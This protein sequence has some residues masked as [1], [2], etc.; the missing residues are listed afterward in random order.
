MLKDQFLLWVALIA[1]V[2]V[3]GLM[4]APSESGHNTVEKRDAK[5]VVGVQQLEFSVLRGDSFESASSENVPRLV[6]RDDTLEAELINQQ[7][8]YLSRLKV[9]SHQ[10]DI[11]ILVDTGSSDLWVMDSV[12]P[13][14]S[15]RSRVKRD[16]HDEKI[17][18]WNPINLKKNETSQNK[19]FWDWLVGTSTSSP[20][21]ATATGSGS[22]SAATAVSVSS[23]QATLDCSTYG[24]F[25]HADSSTFHD[26]NTDF[27]ISYADTTFASGIWGYDDVI[28]DGIEVKELSFA[29]ADMTNSSI[30]VLGIGLKGLESTYAS[31]SSVSEMYQYDNLPAKMV[32]DGLINK[33]AYSL[34]LNSKDA[35]SGSILF[36]G[37]DHKKYSGQLLTVPVINTLASSG[38]REAIRLQIT[39][40]G[41]DVKKGSDQ[42]TLLQGR[43]A[44]LLDSGATL[45]YAP[46]SVL[47]S[48]GRNLGGSYDSSRQA[49]TIRCVSAS[50]TTSLVFNFGGATVEVSLYDLQIATYYTGGSATQ[51]LIGIFSSG[52]DEFVLG[53]TFLRSAYVV[54]DLDGLE[55]SLAQANFN[56]TDS[57]VEAITS[58]VPSA[59][60]ASGYS[61]TWSGS[62]SGTVYTSVQ[63]ESGAASSSNSSGSNMGS[64]SS[65]S[66]SSSSTSSGDEE[67]G[68]S[69]NRVPFS[70]LSLCLVVI[71]FVW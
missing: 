6:R 32:T 18:E 59:T 64:S 31:A 28:I 20:S 25:D 17:A 42:G 41:I 49:Y 68:S 33:N 10:A 43:F 34:Y 8:F 63:M 23:A 12:N 40:N 16:I 3:S 57:D 35:S 11:G 55:V 21:T 65:S 4:A 48:I 26:N 37:V 1:S 15:S 7:S 58:S 56:E 62:A 70:Y 29:V 51:C 2:P 44:A 30:G 50:D 67:G 71:L 45:T 60:R 46:S 66:S 39:L 54:Y 24:T 52:S 36:G 61:S 22:G 69:A 19:N 53:D 5:N 47:N 14:C 13:Y 38:Y 9:G 27:F